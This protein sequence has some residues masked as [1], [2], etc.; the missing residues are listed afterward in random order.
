[1]FNQ[2]SAAESF[3]L[4]ALSSWELI[5]SFSPSSNSS[6]AS[7]TVSFSPD[8]RIPLVFFAHLSVF[9]ES[10]RILLTRSVAT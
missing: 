2:F 6:C 5:L 9:A 8:S 3:A 4:S 10:P 1:L 7:C